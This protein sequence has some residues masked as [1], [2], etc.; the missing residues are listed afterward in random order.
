MVR[1]I[2]IIVLIIGTTSSLFAQKNPA[3]GQYKLVWEDNFNETE[4]NGENWNIEVNGDGGGNQELQYYRRENISLGAEPQSGEGCLIITAKKENYLGKS[5]TSGRL[6][7]QNKMSFKYGKL[8]ARIKLPQTA[9]GLWPAFW[10]LG[11]DFSKVGW[12]R[13]GEIDI[14]EMGHSDGI[15][16]GTQDRY[17]NGACH[18][19]YYQPAGW[20]PSYANHVTYPYSLQD[21]FH[22]YTI[23]WD[24]EFIRMYVD[25]DKYPNAEPYFEI[26]VTDK[27]SDISTY[28]Y[29]N[30]PY[31]VILNLAVGGNF[32]QI[33]NIN[34]IT[35]LNSGQA[36]MYIDYVRLYQ[37]GD[38]GEEYDGP[39][40]GSSIEPQVVNKI[41]VYPNP[42]K[43][44]IEIKG[45]DDSSFRGEI[46]NLSGQKVMSL[47]G[48]SF[49]NV[50][51]LI[52]G[53]YILR[54]VDDIGTTYSYSL[55]K[56]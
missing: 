52:S 53:L 17:L 12:P 38:E 8:E 37:R 5:A 35:A 42:A 15:K 27:S 43:D 56:D 44:Y 9:N 13:S 50:S 55:L 31:F 2:M 49:V 30:K 24:D 33:W 1:I 39:Q 54:I 4:L 34:Q 16:N 40:Q 32:T 48:T 3:T 23:V 19:G 14:L 11:A 28:Y 22:L 51:S 6:T 47:S 26:G 45:L 18:W 7:T 20:Y 46:V 29:F 10:M 25:Q 41:S 36:E 21:D